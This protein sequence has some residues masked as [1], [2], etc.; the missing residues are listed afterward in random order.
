MAF[1]EHKNANIYWNSLGAGEPVVLIMGLGCSSAMWF[2]IAPQ[3]ARSYRVILL[4]NLHRRDK[5]ASQSEPRLEAW[6][7]A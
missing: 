7:I 1:V 6:A 5:A 2:R 3:L 4:D